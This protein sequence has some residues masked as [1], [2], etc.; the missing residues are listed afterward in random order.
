MKDFL[1]TSIKNNIKS[2]L[3]IPSQKNSLNLLKELGFTPKTVY[4]IGAYKGDFAKLVSNT[5]NEPTIYCFEVLESAIKDIEKI[6]VNATIKIIPSL[7]GS[8]N[9]ESIP[10][11]EAETASSILSEHFHQDFPV[12]NF[13]MTRL[14]TWSNKNGVYPDLIKIDT[15]GYEYQVLMGCED[16]IEN[17]QVIIAELNFLDIHKDVIL[18]SEIISYLKSKNFVPFDICELHRRPLD[19]VLWQVDFVFCKEDSFLRTDKRWQK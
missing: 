19:N 6:K 10:F 5:W 16:I 2:R 8:Q 12:H 3:N 13:P 7:A 4:D 1:V 17:V 15:Q 14:D 9:L 11:H 18:V